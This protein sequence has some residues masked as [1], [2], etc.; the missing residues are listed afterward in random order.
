MLKGLYWLVVILFLVT[1]CHRA[2]PDID[3]PDDLEHCASIPPTLSLFPSENTWE[4][5][6][7]DPVYPEILYYLK[8]TYKIYNAEK[9]IRKL[10]IYQF[11]S[12]NLRLNNY[13]VYLVNNPVSDT[14]QGITHAGFTLESKFEPGPNDWILFEDNRNNIW[15]IKK[16]G[17]HPKKLREHANS[18][19]WSKDGTQILFFDQQT[20]KNTIMDLDGSTKAVLNVSNGNLMFSGVPGVLVG[21]SSNKSSNEIFQYNADYQHKTNTSTQDKSS[22]ITDIGLM[23]NGYEAIMS[24]KDW[25]VKINLTDSNTKEYLRPNC[26]SSR[27]YEMP[28]V[29]PDGNRVVFTKKTKDP[30]DKEWAIDKHEIYI[31][32]IRC[33]H[34]K[35]LQ[36]P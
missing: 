33:W 31:M 20:R 25:I 18:P 23:P 34:A 29:S 22:E 12:Y 30:L 13:R 17:S 35:K 15:K 7:F 19:S 6:K 27:S 10:P 11:I 14:L 3:S 4:H 16:D 28:N 21:L 26:Y 8:C 1:A 9:H 2:K 36:L 32:D 24:Q 5:A